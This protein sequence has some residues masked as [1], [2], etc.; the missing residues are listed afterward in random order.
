MADQ[1]GKKPPF[2]TTSGTPLPATPAVKGPDPTDLLKSGGVGNES[3]KGGGFDVTKQSRRQPVPGEAP[4][5]KRAPMPHEQS[6]PQRPVNM[7]DIQPNQ[8]PQPGPVVD[9][10]A[11]TR[12]T[13]T[14]TG[15]VG[16]QH[17]PFK[18]K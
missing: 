2:V 12:E 9:A 11:K 4:P 10:F 14:G 18:V 6:R 3:E 7:G 15:S 5:P 16:N 17:R 1:S 8:V 13:T